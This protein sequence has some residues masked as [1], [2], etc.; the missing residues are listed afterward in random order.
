MEHLITAEGLKSDP[1]KTQAI[2]FMQKPKDQAAMQR[3]LGLSKFL[4]KL[5][6]FCEPLRELTKKNADWVW[7]DKQD[8]AF[9]TIKNLVIKATDITA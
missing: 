9:E 7:S 3:Y 5:S 1:R 8:R 6:T 2:Q 4:P